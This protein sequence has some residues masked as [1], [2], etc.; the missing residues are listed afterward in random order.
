VQG[1]TVD[2]VA[3]AVL[4]AS[5][6]LVAVAARS[7]AATAEDVTLPQFRALV[8]LARGTAKGMSDLAEELACSPSTA[9][10][11]CDRLVRKRLV[12]RD[13][14]ASNR[15]EVEVAVT[16]RGLQ[17]V[18]QVTRRRREEIAHIVSQVPARQRPAM[19]AALR[20]FAEAAGEAPDQVWA[21]G[22]DL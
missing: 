14:P 16:K 6:A 17:L 22:W 2:D 4:L 11:L 1:S 20:T 8:V 15:R 5:R 3:D 12:A 21:S 10:R 7:L 18:E 19:V 13:H 9:T